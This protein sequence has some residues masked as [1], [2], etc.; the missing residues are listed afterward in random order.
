MSMSSLLLPLALGLVACLYAAVGHAGATGYIAVMGLFGIGPQTIRPTALILNVIVGTI[1][2][3]QFTRAGHVRRELLLP[4]AMASVPA[5]A[6]GG[7]LRLPTAVFE[8]IVG[9]VLLFSA[10][11]NFW[12]SAGPEPT[13]GPRRALPA[14]ALTALG[15]L[16]GLLSGLTGVGGG[17]FL[18]PALLVLNAAPVKQVAA[19]SAPFILVNS[20]AG[21]AGWSLAG[22]GVPT[23]GLAL[24]A[25]VIIGGL[26]GAELGAFRVPP[27]GLRLLMAIVSLIAGVKLVMRGAAG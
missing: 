4:L 1:A 21:L 6:I 12:H 5:A 19:V 10:I 2:T 8:G 24:I 11:Q 14:A 9:V 17:V 15:S 25:A 23:I 22:N 13:A 3:A 18:T 20:L 7:W 16:L 26:V 27:R